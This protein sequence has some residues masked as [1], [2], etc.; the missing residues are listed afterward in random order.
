MGLSL[1]ISV[2]YYFHPLI[3]FGQSGFELPAQMSAALIKPVAGILGKTLSPFY[4]SKMTIDEILAMNSVVSDRKNLLNLDPEMLSLIPRERLATMKIDEILKDPGIGPLIK[5][6][7]WQ[8]ARTLN[9]LVVAQQ[10]EEFAKQMG[11]QLEG[12][13]NMEQVLTKLVNTTINK[14]A[15]PYAKEVSLI[16]AVLLFFFLRFVFGIVGMIA[17]ILARMIFTILRAV[18]FIEVVT[19]MKEAETIKL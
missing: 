16:I 1:I 2:V 19:V 10:R 13:E 15:S 6:Q 12:N 4:D 3:K 5:D 14:F 11:L 7:L 17:I 18:G 9:P 8:K